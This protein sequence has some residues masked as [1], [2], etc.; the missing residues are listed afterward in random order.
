[1]SL[2]LGPK[3]ITTVL[4]R[5][6]YALKAADVE[7]LGGYP[8]SAFLL[9]D[10]ASHVDGRRPLGLPV[11]GSGGEPVPEQFLEDS[12]ASALRARLDA[13]DAVTLKP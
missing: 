13:L 11:F 1:M 10:S 7:T 9:S 6:P 4:L 5:V 12:D 2:R 3:R 8:L